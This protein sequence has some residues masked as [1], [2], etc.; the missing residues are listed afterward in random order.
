MLVF[1]K[2][3]L[4]KLTF[5]YHVYVYRLFIILTK[6]KISFLMYI[7][8]LFSLMSGK[9][10]YF[11]SVLNKFKTYKLKILKKKKNI[12]RHVTLTKNVA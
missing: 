3:K 8:A 2:K 6:H 4:F 7:F 10:F 1:I 12:F 11:E 9:Y 5:I